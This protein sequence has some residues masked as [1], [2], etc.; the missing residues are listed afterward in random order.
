VIRRSFWIERIRDLWRDPED[1]AAW[2][3]RQRGDAPGQGEALS[4]YQ[5]MGASGCTDQLARE[6]AGRAA[7]T[8]ILYMLI[9][10]NSAASLAP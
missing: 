6:L 10:Y 1:A 4:L 9:M 8:W 7:R 2:L 3:A 5:E